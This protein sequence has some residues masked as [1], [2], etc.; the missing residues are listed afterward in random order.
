MAR[1]FN[2]RN[3]ELDRKMLYYP[4]GRGSTNFCIWCNDQKTI[5]AA[6]AGCFQFLSHIPYSNEVQLYSHPGVNL[7]IIISNFTINPM[8]R[9]RLKWIPGNFNKEC[10]LPIWKKLYNLTEKIKDLNKRFSLICHL[11]PSWCILPLL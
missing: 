4:N 8:T 9:T 2:R 6:R 7:F 11:L 1:W 10:V 5:H 3:T